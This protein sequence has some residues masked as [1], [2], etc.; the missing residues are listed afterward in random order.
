[1]ETFRIDFTLSNPFPDGKKLGE[2]GEKNAAQLII[3]PPENLASR[4]EITSYVIAFSTEKGPVRY[5][6]VDKAETLTVPVSNALTVGTA[7]SVQVEGYDADGEFIIKSPVLNGISVSNS[8]SSG[9]RSEE[10][11][12]IPGH[13]HDNLELLNCFRNINGLLLYKN[14]IISDGTEK[15]VRPVELNILKG[16]FSV[17][18]DSPYPNCLIFIAGKNSGGEML[19]PEGHI[20][21]SIEMNISDSE[22]PVWIDLR[23]MNDSELFVPYYISMYK[24]VYSESYDG[25]VLACVYFP[26]ET[27]NLYQAAANYEINSLRVVYEESGEK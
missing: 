6:P 12:V 23:D 9:N 16:G 14:R 10:D 21:R 11:S 5:G 20:I 2:C 4:K 25:T 22:N 3:T 19:I 8:I 17:F 24:S 18:S 27:T 26:F 7:L 13:V 15:Y 1:M